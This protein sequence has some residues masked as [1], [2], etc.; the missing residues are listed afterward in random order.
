MSTSCDISQTLSQYFQAG[1]VEVR[2]DMVDLLLSE[3]NMFE[4]MLKKMD[5]DKE[6]GRKP[7]LDELRTKLIKGMNVGSDDEKKRTAE[8][9]IGAVKRGKCSSID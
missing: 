1:E 3:A 9:F 7:D 2:V 8:K 6:S 4:A 5:E